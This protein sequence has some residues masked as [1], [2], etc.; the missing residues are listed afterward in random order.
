MSYYDSGNSYG[1]QE[2]DFTSDT[3]NQESDDEANGAET[4][5]DYSA[6]P[7][8]DEV[9]D[10]TKGAKRA[11]NADT[12]GEAKKL[13]NAAGVPVAPLVEPDPDRNA[14]SELNMKVPGIEFRL[15][16]MG[17]L[18]HAPLFT[19]QVTVAGKTFEAESNTKKK[20]RMLAAQ[21]ALNYMEK[22]NITEEDET[23]RKTTPKNPTVILNEIRPHSKYEFVEDDEEEGKR[24]F[25]MKLTLDDHEYFGK[26]KSKAIAKALAACDALTKLC[27]ITF[28]IPE[29]GT[30]PIYE[31]DNDLWLKY[32]KPRLNILFED[33]NPINL[34][35]QLYRPLPFEIEEKR[36]DDFRCKIT[37][38][39][40]MFHG[41]GGS[42]QVAKAYASLYALEMLRDRQLLE[43]R[44]MEAAQQREIYLAELKA[45]KEA[46][47]KQKE[48]EAAAA[49][50]VE[51]S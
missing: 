20:A 45:R 19:M 27:S 23:L 2:D 29:D 42:R 41:A 5:Y 12:N 30:M 46:E 36:E 48:L 39:G 15:L 7:T 50:S 9:E 22:N 38:E 18:I 47:Q 26:G 6:T 11:I 16:S 44:K 25:L 51:A 40:A 31:G 28:K 33:Q 49:Q 1:Y 21:C 10:S 14:V 4:A 13:K 32:K 35:H 34:M 17:G 3:V 43:T 37:V 24:M 8:Y